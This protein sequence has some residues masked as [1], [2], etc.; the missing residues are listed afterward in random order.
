M[1]SKVADRCRWENLGYLDGTPGSI[2]DIQERLDTYERNTR[3]YMRS[4]RMLTERVASITAA[5]NDVLTCPNTVSLQ[6]FLDELER[7]MH[8]QG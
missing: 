7:A 8:E 1:I 4:V 6:P 2:E 5:A 3:L